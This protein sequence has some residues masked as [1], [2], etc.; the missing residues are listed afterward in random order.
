MLL[1][2]MDAGYGCADIL[3][4]LIYIQMYKATDRHRCSN[5]HID[6]PTDM[7]TDVWM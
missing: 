5:R 7:G 3:V 1:N 6:V 4:D 2:N